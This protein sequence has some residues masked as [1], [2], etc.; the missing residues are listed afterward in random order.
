VSK[1][2]HTVIVIGAGASVAEAK[3][4]KPTRSKD[5]PP[6]DSTFFE[7]VARHQKGN[8]LDRIVARAASLGYPDICTTVPSLSLEQYLG[9]LFFEMQNQRSE[10]NVHAYFDL[11]RLYSDELLTTTNWMVGRDA[12]IKRLLNSA[13]AG[14][15]RVTVVTFNHDLLVENALSQMSARRH[16]NVWCLKH[17]Y[18]VG[19]HDTCSSQAF[20]TFDYECPGGPEDH[21]PIL[22]LHG[23]INWVFRAVAAYPP[24]DFA[25][26]KRKLFLWNNRELPPEV[27]RL[28]YEKSRDWYLWPLIVPPIYEKH[29][30]IR[31]ELEGVWSRA[32]AAL[33]DCSKVVF[34]GYS[35]PRADL[36]A[37]YFFQAAAQSNAALREP[38]F[39]NPDPAAHSELCQ[40]LAPGKVSYYH[41]VT[42]Y[43]N[44]ES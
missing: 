21:V 14:R 22:K 17:C 41:D 42:D 25:R 12:S 3:W 35:F 7:R 27:N 43:L 13:R 15:R 6:L 5:H 23:S 38:V 8:L 40:V 39:I 24:A 29:G 37:R 2:D 19:I 30:L 33:R 32:D 44:D 1:N 36:H 9:R 11:V 10:E 28:H 18:G 26:R 34:W 20:D 4:H 31:N 16:G